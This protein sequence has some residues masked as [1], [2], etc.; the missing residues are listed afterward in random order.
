MF[1]NDEE[2]ERGG[3]S[4]PGDLHRAADQGGIVSRR[5]PVLELAISIHYQLRADVFPTC[6]ASPG[7]V[8]LPCG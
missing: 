5:E 8:S 7:D 2:H 1:A 6:Q 3:G 4:D